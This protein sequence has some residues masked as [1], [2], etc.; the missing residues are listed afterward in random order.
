MFNFFKR[1]A[2]ETKN[3]TEGLHLFQARHRIDDAYL[4]DILGRATPTGEVANDIQRMCSIVESAIGPLHAVANLRNINRNPLDEPS[5]AYIFGWL[6]VFKIYVW[7][8]RDFNRSFFHYGYLIWFLGPNEM[9]RFESAMTAMRCLGV[10]AVDPSQAWK[11]EE[12]RGR[13]E[14][15]A[16]LLEK[17]TPTGPPRGRT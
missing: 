15:R 17:R 10:N 11:A 1:K 12:K 6:D 5:T 4:A 13:D 7:D 16:F 2:P 14:A 8:V 3:P 9:E